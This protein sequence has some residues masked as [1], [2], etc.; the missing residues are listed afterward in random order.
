MRA[1]P[2]VL[3]GLFL[4]RLG[5]RGRRFSWILPPAAA[6]AAQACACHVRPSARIRADG[7]VSGRCSRRL[8]TEV[9]PLLVDGGW[10]MADGGWRSRLWPLLQGCRG[11]GH[12]Y[13]RDVGG[14]LRPTAMLQAVAGVV[15]GLSRLRAMLKQ[16][17]KSESRIQNPESR[18][19]TGTGTG[20]GAE[21]ETETETEIE[22]G[23]G[24]G[25]G[26]EAMSAAG[27][28]GRAPQL[29]PGRGQGAR[30]ALSASRSRRGSR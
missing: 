12:S 7:H 26:A 20:T 11:W 5:P 10:R 22:A 4:W 15:A 21:T 14:R 18:T 6:G 28:R 13:R 1:P 8:P 23:A 17:P 30:L 2:A 25:A 29:V 27:H 19:G 16:E 3:A 24:A 9:E